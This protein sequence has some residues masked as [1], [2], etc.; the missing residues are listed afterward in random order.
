MN[1]RVMS[2]KMPATKALNEGL[3][4]LEGLGCWLAHYD[5]TYPQYMS[6]IEKVRV[7]LK[8]KQEIFLRI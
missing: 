2:S 8:Y 7:F 4:M 3:I 1:E 5:D 6:I